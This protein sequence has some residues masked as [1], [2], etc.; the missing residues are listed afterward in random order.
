MTESTKDPISQI[1]AQVMGYECRLSV[2]QPESS[3]VLSGISIGNYSIKNYLP[4]TF[5]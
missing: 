5:S 4:M 3:I 2:D 1:V